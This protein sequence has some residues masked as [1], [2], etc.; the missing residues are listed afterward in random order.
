M[1]LSEKTMHKNFIKYFSAKYS[2]V[3]IL[4]KWI[5]GQLIPPLFFSIAAFT[6]VSLSVGILFDLIR[7]MVE[8]GLPITFALK[9]MIFKLPGFLVIS[10]PMSVLLSTL[11]AYGKLS[12]NSELLALKSLG[13]NKYR[14]LAPALALSIFMTGLTFYFNNSLVPKT[15]KSAEAL[16]RN[17][18]DTSVVIERGQD[19]FFPGYTV[20]TDPDTNLSSTNTYLT[21]IFFSRVVENNVMKNVTVMDFS[22]KGYKQILSAKEGTFQKSKSAW[23]FTDGRLITLDENGNTTTIGFD[24]YTYPLG[25]GPLKVSKIPK[26]ANEMTVN[27]AIEAK[28]LYLQSGNIR[29]ARKMSVR[30]QEKFTFP[31]ACVVFAL[32]GSSLGSKSN[33]RSSR[34]Q[35][36]GLSVILILIYYVL[37]FVSSAFGVK[38]ILS[39]FLSAW[40][41]VIISLFGGI[42]LLKK[43][44]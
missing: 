44:T 37:S 18:L 29:E 24:K 11:L 34:S 21:Q 14:I 36:F 23:I 10:F 43:S 27:Q 38:G 31:F 41:P 4:D 33:L 15:N 22:K 6:V 5:L 16:L 42:Y 12:S 9:I 17:G 39:P 30:I 35:G 28:K 13:I 2:N 40:L 7:K 19:I 32:I 3:P 25:D 26:D 1:S 20:V 8:Y